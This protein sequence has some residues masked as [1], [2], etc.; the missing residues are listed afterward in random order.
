M[1][2]VDPSWILR[3]RSDFHFI[4]VSSDLDWIQVTW[5]AI[6][7]VAYLLHTGS[8]VMSD[9]RNRLWLDSPMHKPARLR[10]VCVARDGRQLNS[11]IDCETN[12]CFKRKYGNNRVLAL[13]ELIQLKTS[14]IVRLAY[15]G[16]PLAD[17]LGVVTNYLSSGVLF[18]KVPGIAM[19]VANFLLIYR[20]KLVL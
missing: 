16:N 12:R 5:E 3:Y 4:P 1:P 6:A 9:S 20:L 19:Q 2:Q 13:E 14:H 15:G 18:D 7:E 10:Y 11:M 8:K 17:V